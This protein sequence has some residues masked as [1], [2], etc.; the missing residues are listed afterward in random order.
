MSKKLKICLILVVVLTTITTVY[1]ALS[2][3]VSLQTKK[4]VSKNEEFVVDVVLSDIQSD[5]GVIALG[6]TL[7]YDK[8]SLTLVKMEGQN[9][10]ATPSYNEKNGILAT[11]RNA[12]TTS[13]ET[14]FKIT[15]KANDNSK[16]DVDIILKD[17]AVANGKDEIE[18]SNSKTTVTVKSGNASSDDNTTKDDN[19]IANNTVSDNKVNNNTTNNDNTVNNT[20]NN[21]NTNNNTTNNVNTSKNNTNVTAN[22]VVNNVSNNTIKAETDDNIKGGLLPKAGEKS[23]VLIVLVIVAIIAAVFYIKIQ[24]INKKVNKH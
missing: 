15:F 2:C 16:K 7:E 19:K 21:N 11:D 24:N 17:I 22:K 5:R 23:I 12:L 9:G 6:A 4:E 10:W 3:K 8:D 18:L 1:A 20:T 13:D 14:V